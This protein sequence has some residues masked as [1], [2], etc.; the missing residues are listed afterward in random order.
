MSSLLRF[1]ASK[2]AFCWA[3]CFASAMNALVVI[4]EPLNWSISARWKS[5]N[6]ASPTS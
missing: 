6:A 4:V 3:I 5:Q 2:P 1:E